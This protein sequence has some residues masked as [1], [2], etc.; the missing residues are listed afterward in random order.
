MTDG[1]CAR[2][3]VIR[4]GRDFIPPNQCVRPVLIGLFLIMGLTASLP[5][6]ELTP[7]LVVDGGMEQWITVTP[8][9][10]DWWEHL[11]RQKKC[12]LSYDE[13]QNILMPRALS[14]C[15]GCKV[16][17]RET[18]DVYNGKY[19]LRLMEGFYVRVAGLEAKDGDVL[20]ARFRV[21]GSGRVR[22]YPHCSDSARTVQTLELTGEA[23]PD[24]WSLIEQR[25]LVTGD[26]SAK[27][28]FRLVPSAE[29]LIDDVFLA[30]VLRP[31]ERRLEQVPADLQKRV[32]FA[33]PAS[34]PITLDG[35]LDEPAW[36]RAVEFRGFRRHDNQ[37]LLAAAQPDFQVSF[38][39]QA[40]YFAVKVPLPNT[41]Q[42][43]E[44]LFGQPLLD[45]D[46]KLRS[47]TDTFSGRHSVEI[48]LQAPGQS[49]YRQLVVSVDGYRYDGIGM[50][51]SWNGAWSSAVQVEEDG[52]RLEIRVPT[53]DLG[54]NKT[55][56]IKGW[57]LNLCSNQPGA[58]STWTAVGG[59]FHNPDAFGELIA[60][61]FPTWCK[62]Q[63]AQLRQKC[64]AIL[65]A[66]GPRA[67]LYADRL[68]A[69]E[70]AAAPDTASEEATNWKAITRAY[71]RMD[72]L[73]SAY[74]R[75]EEEIRYRQYFR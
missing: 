15:G 47:R 60:Q 62:A 43:L 68:A 39:E 54:V 26:G 33:W 72:F 7:N 34:G 55:A 19:A 30:R 21:K 56:P 9:T 58:T 37:S 64:A 16:M 41:A 73:G 70:V 40:L 65:Q 75:V 50:D 46:G 71:A 36:D 66:A 35:K 53:A 25:M 11:T 67:S 69:F 27:I 48:F 59:N 5:A 32:A 44:E 20:V 38:D 17:Q 10:K 3:G 13:Q 31:G 22:F 74:R 12:A 29:M 4:N 28:A 24:R 49:G 1:T 61:D 52:W 2:S 63:P 23:D 42:V 8:T 18:V 51:G 6:A 14:Q 45:G 57:R